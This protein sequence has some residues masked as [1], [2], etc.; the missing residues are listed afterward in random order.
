MNRAKGKATW[1]NPGRTRNLEV[2]VKALSKFEKEKKKRKGPEREKKQ[3][4]GEEG[5]SDALRTSGSLV[6]V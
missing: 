4:Q 3:Q 1:P 2:L 6:R 5:K